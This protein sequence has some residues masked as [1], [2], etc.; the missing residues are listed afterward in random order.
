LISRKWLLARQIA[1]P[2]LQQATHRLSLRQAGSSTRAT[3]QDWLVAVHRGS[4]LSGAVLVVDN[5]SVSLSNDHDVNAKRRSE[6]H[7]DMSDAPAGGDFS[8]NAL[9]I[10]CV[11]TVTE[12]V[13]NGEYVARVALD[14][15]V[16][17]G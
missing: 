7:H 17:F 2:P 14:R 6:C 1:I 5:E 13:G 4:G 10:R 3:T 11:L 8:R 9:A 12:H 15:G 16:E